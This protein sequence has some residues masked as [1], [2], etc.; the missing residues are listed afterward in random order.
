MGQQIAEMAAKYLDDNMID[1]TDRDYF[2]TWKEF[3]KE[4]EFIARGFMALGL[5]KLIYIYLGN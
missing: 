3:N 5:K 1:Y 2:G 4:C